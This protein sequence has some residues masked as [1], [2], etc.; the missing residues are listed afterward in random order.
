[1]EELEL[2][3]MTGLFPAEVVDKLWV[4]GS[5][6][7]VRFA[8]EQRD[9]SFRVIDNARSGLQN[10]A[11][12]TQ[13]RIHTCSSSASVAMIRKFKSL[14]EG[15]LCRGCAVVQRIQDMKKAFRQVPIHDD[16]LR[17]FVIAVWDP[18]STQWVFF[19]MFAM[20]F[21][22]MSA[23]LQFN[24]VPRSWLL[25]QVA[26]LRFQSWVFYDDFKIYELEAVG[27]DAQDLFNEVV[28]W[29][30]FHLDPK[31]QQDFARRVK[32][33]GGIEEVCS[34]EGLDTF[35]LRPTPD[36]VGMIKDDINAILSSQTVCPSV[37]SSI[38]GKLVHVATSMA[39]RLGASLTFN[40]TKH[41]SDAGDSVD[42]A[43]RR[44]LCWA[45]ALLDF[46]PWR[47]VNL[48]FEHECTTVIS[49]AS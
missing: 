3:Y 1:M 13:E 15:P 19:Q 34:N 31:K 7:I 36:R 5:G 21:V 40:I 29:L 4:K 37:L 49:D 17:F 48:T 18:R 25:W 42:P 14:V 2:G 35:H 12:G 46:A 22:L 30:D 10:D 8:T 28:S 26:G 32:F 39:G 33:F 47:S 24:R 9:G 43:L 16:S 6:P 45:M 20:P 41:L 38:R 44:E 27:K 11:T 23:V